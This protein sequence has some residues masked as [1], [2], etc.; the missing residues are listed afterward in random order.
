MAIAEA[1]L[2]SVPEIRSGLP[3]T[4]DEFMRLPKDG[5]RNPRVAKFELVDG[6]LKEVP[7]GFDHD[8]IALDLILLL[9]PHMKGR[10]AGTTGQTGFRMVGSNV[11]APD[12]SFTR[13]ERLPGGEAPEGFGD[14]A[15]DLCIEII[16]PSEER[17]EMACKVG[18]YFASGAEQVWQVF[19]ERR[20]VVVFTS[21]TAAQTLDAEDR[22]TAGDILP[23]FACQV[24]ELF[25]LEQ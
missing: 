2:K 4:E 15:P 17:A 1:E 9:G 7:T 13:K 19:P 10:G 24:R 21:P 6:R 25:T 8:A 12:V 11:R 18:E 16:S 23:E 20:Q 3:M 14:V 5:P 22:L